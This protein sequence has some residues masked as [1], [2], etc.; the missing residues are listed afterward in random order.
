ME[1]I[2]IDKNLDLL[3]SIRKYRIKCK[4]I[5]RRLDKS[6]KKYNEFMYQL[7]YLSNFKKF[8]RLTNKK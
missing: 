1:G 5:M 8:M 3:N 7:A 2:F 4:R 6:G